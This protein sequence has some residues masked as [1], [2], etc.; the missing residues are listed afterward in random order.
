MFSFLGAHDLPLIAGAI[1]VVYSLNFHFKKVIIKIIIDNIEMRE[2]ACVSLLHP[3]PSIQDS[4]FI[5]SIGLRLLWASIYDVIS[6][7]LLQN[8]I[9]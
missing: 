2:I 7:F 4:P 5:A 9:K 3:I 1:F 6:D 8:N